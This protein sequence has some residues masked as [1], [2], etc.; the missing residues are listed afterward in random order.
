M[1][2]RAFGLIPIFGVC[3]LGEDARG[4][5]AFAITC[6]GFKGFVSTTSCRSVCCGLNISHCGSATPLMTSYFVQNTEI[7]P[8]GVHSIFPSFTNESAT[9]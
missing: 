6:C 8:F 3:I 2:A 4:V 9:I 5:S 7:C 1:E